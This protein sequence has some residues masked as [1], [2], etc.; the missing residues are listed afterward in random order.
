MVSEYATVYS[1]FELSEFTFN[2]IQFDLIAWQPGSTLP[3]ES[4]MQF[5]IRAVRTGALKSRIFKIKQHTRGTLKVNSVNS[6]S[7]ERDSNANRV[8]LP[9]NFGACEWRS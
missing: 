6:W 8:W 5:G 9:D 2:L 3:F 7:V 4:G 1:G